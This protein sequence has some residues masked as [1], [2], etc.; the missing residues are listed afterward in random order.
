MPLLFAGRFEEPVAEEPV[1]RLR[2]K[3]RLP[4]VTPL[5]DVLRLTGNSV[6]GNTCRGDPVRFNESSDNYRA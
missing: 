4:I 3:K 5:N 1:P 6:T 2:R